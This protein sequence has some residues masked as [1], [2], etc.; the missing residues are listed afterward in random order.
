MSKKLKV[1]HLPTTVGGNPQGIS[2]H[3]KELGVDS[4]TW[5]LQ[6]NYFGYPADK[7]LLSN[8]SNR[9]TSELVKIK[10]L[11]YIFNFDV[12]FFNFGRGLFTPFFPVRN[13]G[14]S[15]LKNFLIL[16]LN[17]YNTLMSKL[18]VILLRKMGIPI[19]IQYQGDDA[20][21]GDY[22]LANF[23]ISFADKVDENYYNK[24]SDLA[25]RKSI[26]FYENV[27]HKIYALNPDLL[28]VLPSS[29]EFLPYSHVNLDEWTPVFTQLE[30]RPLRIGH[31]PSHR[32]V[33]GTD[34]FLF[35]CD[36]L[37][38]FGYE[39]EIVLV[40]G[41]S[42]AEAKEI[43][44]TIDVLVDQLFAGWYGGLSVE[45]MALGKPVVVYLREEDLHFV[46][47]QMRLDL[48]FFKATPTSIIEVLKLI[49]E[50]P[51]SELLNV[52]VKSRQF[53]EDW[54]N[55]LKIAEKIKKD[56]EKLS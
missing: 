29:A 25:K 22:C 52:A 28:H 13:K 32:A 11:S 49:L 15:F 4:T 50:M 1:I 46:P 44:K 20:R 47:T 5:T 33:K 7:V 42:N 43:Y 16:F 8:N 35:A 48:P 36:K 56:M 31:A 14:N 38:E 21:Q 12:V 17:F 2:K 3:L 34:L 26:K 6:Q 40:E 24:N 27:A 9:I 10:Y 23:K 41:K 55:P 51:R 18:E 39:F 54:H 19:F 45:V 53:V 30:D 37:K